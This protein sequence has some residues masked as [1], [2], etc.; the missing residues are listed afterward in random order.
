MR[1]E[2]RLDIVPKMPPPPM[3]E[4]VSGGLEL[5][6]GFLGVASGTVVNFT[7]PCEHHLSSYLYLLSHLPGTEIGLRDQFPL[8]ASC[9]LAKAEANWQL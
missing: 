3:Y 8:D 1:I 7:I 4:Q 9:N 6:P 2:N 5:N